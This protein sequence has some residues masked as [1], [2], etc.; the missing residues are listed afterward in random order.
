[1]KNSY[2]YANIDFTGQSH[3]R[4]TVLGKSDKGRSWWRCKC[5]C[6]RELELPAWR[7]L[8]YKSCGCMEKE[9]K[10][11]LADH[12][13]THGMTD[14]RLYSVWCGMKDRCFN[15]NTEH[16]D[17]YGG[18]GISVCAEWRNSFE[19]FRDWAYANGYKDCLTGKDQSI[20]RIDVNK[21]YCPDN[22]R[23][24]NQ[25]RQMRNTEKAV[26]IEYNGEDIPLMDF[27]EM[28]G[29][30]Y[31]HF[32]YRRLQNG[33]GA[34]QILREWNFSNGDHPDYLDM[35]EAASLYHVCYQSI[36]KWIDSGKI[37]AERVGQHWYVPVGQVVLRRSDRDDKGRFTKR[38]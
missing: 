20:D 4:L 33:M 5:E 3:D 38:R 37:R 13:R 23:W 11:H 29:I 32:V 10:A 36:K 19:T 27:C 17:R 14:T 24:V 8:A 22:C 21:D 35:E 34:D 31:H 15:P 26:L 6:G 25:T 28:H 1:M 16:F 2:K 12:V 30:K 7:Y 18:R 9:N